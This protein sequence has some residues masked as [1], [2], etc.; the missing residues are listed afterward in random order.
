MK[1]NYIQ[2]YR[3][4]GKKKRLE[5][6]ARPAIMH[7]IDT[8]GRPNPVPFLLFFFLP[9]R[10]MDQKNEKPGNDGEFRNL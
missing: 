5:E 6:D 3:F 10:K 4:P 2:Y 8:L 1:Q 9:R 7:L